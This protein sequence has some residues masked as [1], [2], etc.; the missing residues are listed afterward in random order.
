M[1][2]ARA[3]MGSDVAQCFLSDAVKTERNLLRN[4][5]QTSL[6]NAVWL[7][8]NIGTIPGDPVPYLVVHGRNPEEVQSYAS[9][10]DDALQFMR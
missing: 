3:R 10:L 7:A 1:R 6:D 5:V 2:L 8:E 9:R 4:A